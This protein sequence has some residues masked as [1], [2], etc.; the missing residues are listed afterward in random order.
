MIEDGSCTNPFCQCPNCQCDPCECKPGVPCDCG[1]DCHE[2][3]A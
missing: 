1:C 3:K 2:E